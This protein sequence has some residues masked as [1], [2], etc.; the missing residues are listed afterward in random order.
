MSRHIVVFPYGFVFVGDLTRTD[1]Q[2]RLDN[3]ACIRVWGTSNGLGE[4][5]MGG[6]TAATT[7]DPCGIVVAPA[8]SEVLSIPCATDTKWPL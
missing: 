6:P 7:L 8:V 1:K 5:A 2:I 3:A 4:L